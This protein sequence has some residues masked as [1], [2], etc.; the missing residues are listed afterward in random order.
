MAKL[1]EKQK[2]FCEEYVIDLNATQAAIRA[3]YSKKTANRIASQNLSKLD[4]QNYI[5]SLQTKISE[6]LKISATDVLKEII[7]V[8]DR[9]MQAVPVM[10]FDPVDKC[11]VQKENSEGKG[12]WEFNSRDALKALDMMGR[13]IGFYE[14]DNDQL[15][16]I[17]QFTVNVS[18]ESK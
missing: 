2:R 5:Q 16:I 13:H 15:K 10:V 14:K 11:M 12:I 4:I 8:K 18:G 7:E 6:E 1:S 9:C 17:P 3:G